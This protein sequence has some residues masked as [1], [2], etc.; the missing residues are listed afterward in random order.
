MGFFM[1][2]VTAMPL[3]LIC[4]LGND[5]F[6]MCD[7]YVSHPNIKC[8]ASL[9]IRDLKCHIYTHMCALTVCKLACTYKCM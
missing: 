7:Y 3:A 9:T 5:L 8:K 2:F 6:V 1:H 4:L